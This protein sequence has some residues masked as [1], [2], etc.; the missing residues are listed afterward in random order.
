MTNTRPLI[1]YGLVSYDDQDES[2]IEIDAKGDARTLASNV[3]QWFG[4]LVVK[5]LADGDYVDR[6]D[7][8]W[9]EKYDRLREAV[10]ALLDWYDGPPFV[11]E[12]ADMETRLNALRAALRAEGETE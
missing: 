11:Y 12:E 5:R 2:L 3:P 1:S 7:M 6:L 4:R 10:L 9:S 8:L